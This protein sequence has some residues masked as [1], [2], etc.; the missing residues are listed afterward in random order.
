[1]QVLAFV[2]TLALAATAAAI[3]QA[4][5][6][7]VCTCKGADGKASMPAFLCNL[8]GGKLRDTECGGLTAQLTSKDCQSAGVAGATA[9]CSRL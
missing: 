9:E 1:M 8:S 2:L 3:P 5:T 7:F 4:G 6:R